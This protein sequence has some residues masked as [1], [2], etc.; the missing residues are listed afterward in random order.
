M[1]IRKFTNGNKKADSTLRCSQ[2]VPHPSTNRA[3]CR[4]TSE[5]RRDPVHS[6]RYG[7]Q[8]PSVLPTRPPRQSVLGRGAPLAIAGPRCVLSARIRTALVHP[9]EGMERGGGTGLGV[10]V[11]QGCI[12]AAA[13][14]ACIS[15][16]GEEPASVISRCRGCRVF[17]RSESVMSFAWRVGFAEACKCR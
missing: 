14:G 17:A 7:R 11:H 8:Q 12:G 15:D 6:T 16:Q 5:V 13:R 10:R 9:L 3:L 2:A 1:N 4:L